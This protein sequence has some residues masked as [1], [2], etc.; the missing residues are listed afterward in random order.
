M[1]APCFKQ[2]GCWC[3]QKCTIIKYSLPQNIRSLECKCWF[4]EKV[5]TSLK[6]LLKQCNYQRW[7]TV[8]WYCDIFPT[9]TFSISIPGIAKFK[10]WKRGPHNCV[11][12]EKVTLPSGQTTHERKNQM[13]WRY[14]MLSARCEKYK[15]VLLL[16]IFLHFTTQWT[17]RV[18]CSKWD[19]VFHSKQNNWLEWRKLWETQR[20]QGLR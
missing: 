4:E 15:R 19:E 6:L 18:K 20:V 8:K 12:Q 1:I 7:C 17:L 14:L 3:Q 9:N 11:S 5:L 2:L 16:N 13:L 10:N